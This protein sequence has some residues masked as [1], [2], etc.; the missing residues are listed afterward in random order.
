MR[1]ISLAG[2]CHS[3]LPPYLK[4]TK[5]IKNIQNTD[6]RCF[7]YALLWFLDPPRDR[8][9]SNRLTVFTKQMFERNQLANLYYPISPIDVHFYEDK[10]QINIKVFSFVDDE[11][12]ARHPLC[13]SKK[14]TPKQQICYTGINITRNHRHSAFCFWHKQ[15]WTMQKYMPSV[16]R[17][18]LHRRVFCQTLSLVHARRHF[19]SHAR[20]FCCGNWA[21]SN[22]I[23]SSP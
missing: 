10:L 6:D 21:S 15:T 3:E 7:G 17:K 20:A 22:R 18:L 16:S 19:V 12:K 1:Y 23:Q 9:H 4:S 8:I 5:A 2:R 14:F 13:I 11:S